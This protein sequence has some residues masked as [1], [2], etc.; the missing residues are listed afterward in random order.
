MQLRGTA[1]RNTFLQRQ[2]QKLTIFWLA[3]ELQASTV[4]NDNYTA[5]ATSTTSQFFTLYVC[6]F[7][8]R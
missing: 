3:G 5:S 4:A 6:D 8:H 7:L 2:Q 1:F